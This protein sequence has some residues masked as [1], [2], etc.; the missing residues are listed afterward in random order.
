MTSVA[1]ASPT[2]IRWLSVGDA[3]AYLGVSDST[4]R[5]WADAGELPSHR[6]PGGHRRFSEADL[7]VL[8]VTPG[9]VS[10]V[11]QALAGKALTRIRR[12]METPSRPSATWTALFSDAERSAMREH[13]RRLVDLAGEY[14]QHPRRR[15]RIA[16]EALQIGASYGRAMDGHHLPLSQALDTFVFFRNLVEDS[17][18]S[19]SRSGVSPA[20]QQEL[21]R[22]LAGLLDQV[23][24]G[25]V[26]A[27]E[28]KPQPAFAGA[29]A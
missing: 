8:L 28:V 25:I 23:M 6:T 7:A 1:T 18:G 16:R 21:Y 29:D 12:R 14:L 13:G 4:L 19:V 22:H 9:A 26:Q 3:A 2:L 24:R 11:G 27:Y 10:D 15:P 17:A 20:Q 5:A